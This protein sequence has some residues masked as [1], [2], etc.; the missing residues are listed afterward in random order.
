[1]R[2][3]RALGQEEASLT[4]QISEL[5]GADAIKGTTTDGTETRVVE[6]IRG[7]MNPTH[8]EAAQLATRA[9]RRTNGIKRMTTLSARK[10]G[11]GTLRSPYINLLLS[12]P[13]PT[14]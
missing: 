4:N 8:T 6:G 2:L 10:H 1:M 7:H 14:K 5:V 3:R 9:L 11:S 12:S 13:A